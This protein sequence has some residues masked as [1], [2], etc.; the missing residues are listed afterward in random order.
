MRTAL[1]SFAFVLAAGQIAEAG[2]T[3]TGGNIIDQTWTVADSPYLVEGDITIPVGSTLTIES[4]VEVDLAQ[5]DMQQ[6]GYSTSQIEI[7]VHGTLRIEGTAAAPVKMLGGESGGWY[8]IVVTG[9]ATAVQ[10]DHVVLANP[11]IGL[12]TEAAAGVISSFDLDI[13]DASGYGV[14]ATGGAVALDGLTV[15]Q[16]N[17]GV[18]VDGP[19]TGVV[20]TNC[21]VDHTN[22]GLEIEGSGPVAIMVTNC[23]FDHNG[24]GVWNTVSS[25]T[26]AVTNTIITNGNIGI[27]ASGAVVTATYNDVWN[28]DGSN[29]DF[30]NPGPGVGCISANPQYVSAA[31]YHLQASSVAIDTGTTGPDRDIEDHLRPAD[32]DGIGGA[33]WDLG[34][35]EYGSTVIVV[36]SDAGIGG[37]AGGG[38]D[39]VD[40]GTDGSGGD[41]TPGGG[42]TGGAGGCCDSGGAGGPGSLVLAAFAAVAVR[43]RRVR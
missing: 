21:I 42:E 14:W 35:Y 31:D 8:G 39:G 30:V 40:A 37:D 4:G 43:R 20:V 18:L 36:G 11:S 12:R 41:H 13:E 1:V 16:A 38:R 26:I 10:L 33:Q 6:S 9:D 7:T 23:T 29:Y 19:S 15:N 34:A 27:E 17:I 2:T 32:G 24:V 5:G 25:T 22:Y 28:N 3:I